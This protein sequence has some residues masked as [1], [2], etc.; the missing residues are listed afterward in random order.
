M[1]KRKGHAEN[2]AAGAALLAY[3][4]SPT[5]S[6]IA[7]RAAPVPRSTEKFQIFD[8]RTIESERN[9]A[10]SMAYGFLVAARSGPQKNFKNRT[11][12]LMKTGKTSYGQELRRG[13]LPPR[14]RSLRP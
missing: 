6:R 10:Q 3:A 7:R 4:G 13:A 9:Y 1:N 5:P 11:N 8:D 12:E 2:M 14:P